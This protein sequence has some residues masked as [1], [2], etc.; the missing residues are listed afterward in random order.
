MSV[1]RQR[2]CIC[3]LN[4]GVNVGEA[5]QGFRIKQ[6]WITD[7]MLAGNRG[8]LTMLGYDR[9][10]KAHRDTIDDIISSRGKKKIAAIH[11]PEHFISR[12]SQRYEHSHCSCLFCVRVLLFLIDWSCA[13]HIAG[14]CC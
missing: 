2:Q 14:P 9:R 7:E 13:H 1:V 8:W 4:C 12:S 5:G 3:R 11:F 6:G 10:L